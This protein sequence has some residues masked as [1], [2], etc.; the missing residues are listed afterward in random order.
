MD[1]QDAPFLLSRADLDPSIADSNG[2]SVAHT[3]AGFV[4]DHG[5]LSLASLLREMNEAQRSLLALG[6]VR[7]W[8]PVCGLREAVDVLGA[9]VLLIAAK[10]S[11]LAGSTEAE[12]LLRRAVEHHAREESSDWEQLEHALSDVWWDLQPF[13]EQHAADLFVE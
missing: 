13:I 4:G 5:V 11:A 7:S 2:W 1:D 10:G 9:E 6:Q 12:R 8:L 3:L